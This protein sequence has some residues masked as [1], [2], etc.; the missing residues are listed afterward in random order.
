MGELNYKQPMS[1][2]KLMY[3]IGLF[4]FGG[5]LLASIIDSSLYLEKYSAAKLWE[6][7]LF[8]IGSAAVYYG[9]V[10]LMNRKR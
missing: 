10:F 6:F 5:M 9:L 3:M 7:R 1:T 8:T 2:K 4:I